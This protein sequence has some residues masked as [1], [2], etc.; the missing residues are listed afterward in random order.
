MELLQTITELSHEFG[1]EEYVTGGG[2]NTSAKNAEM[3]WIKPSG[4]TLGWLSPERFVPIDRAALRK[5]YTAGMPSNVQEREAKVKAIL[6]DVVIDSDARPSVET[7]LHD[8]LNATYVVHTHPLI[9]NGMT[10]AK[11]GESICT[12]LFPEALWID[13]YDPGYTLCM[14]FRDDVKKYV[15]AHGEEPQIIMLK[16]HGVF[17]AADSAEEIRALYARIISTLEEYFKS[18]NVHI[19]LD[20]EDTPALPEE[21]ELIRS[22]YDEDIC[23]QST[24]KFTCANGPLSPD[25][26]VYGGSYPFTGELTA[27]ALE[28]YKKTYGKLPK[29]IETKTRVYGIG[30]TEKNATLA[31]ETAKAAGL[32]NQLTAA[33]GG[34]EFMTPE[35]LAFIE[36]WEGESYR[37]RMAEQCS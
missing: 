23:I 20:I 34:V 29:I 32:E 35:A 3:M 30:T 11:N 16:N 25:R 19:T 5:I 4:T 21:E 27:E 31:L 1:T 22:L 24:G 36:G 10:C 17:V 28:D 12:E 15:D 6:S 33:C 8:T 9:V 7:P 37:M 2:G 13:F 18:K 14:K 26:I